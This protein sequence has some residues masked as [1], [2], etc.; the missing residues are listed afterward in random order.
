MRYVVGMVLLLACC[1]RESETTQTADVI[2]VSITVS[3][4]IA[5][6]RGSLL[7]RFPNARQA[8]S[9]AGVT[10]YTVLGTT[11]ND[12]AMLGAARIGNLYLRFNG[13]SLAEFSGTFPSVRGIPE[14]AETAVRNELGDPSNVE[15][16][17]FEWIET[18]WN[19]PA[20][21]VTVNE[22]RLSIIPH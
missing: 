9:Q 6:D 5:S 11:T 17:G 3:D 2:P 22:I 18:T 1:T 4:I 8:E 19:R 12:V 13:E 15:T 21:T 10:E 14:A 7:K 16:N 20:A